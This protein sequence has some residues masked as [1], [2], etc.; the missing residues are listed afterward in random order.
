MLHVTPATAQSPSLEQADRHD[1]PTLAHL[2]PFGHGVL[3]PGGQVLATPLHELALVRVL[4]TH[5]VIEH[6]AVDV[7]Q[8]PLL[9][10]PVVPQGAVVAHPGWGAGGGLPERFVHVPTLP[11]TLHAWHAPPQ[12]LLQQTPSAQKPEVQSVPKVHTMPVASFS[13]QR[14]VW[15]LHGTPTQSTLVA[16]EVAH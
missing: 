9:H 12:A 14:C 13:P 11:V 10:W 1:A 3:V 5:V 8:T 2:S 15:V 6:M 7:A 16:Q 4:T